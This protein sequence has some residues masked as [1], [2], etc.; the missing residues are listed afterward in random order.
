MLVKGIPSAPGR[1]GGGGDG[2]AE[3]HPESMRMVGILGKMGLFDDHGAPL[4]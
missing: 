3:G 4:N 2:V 1:L